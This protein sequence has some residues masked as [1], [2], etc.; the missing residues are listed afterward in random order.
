M[1]EGDVDIRVHTGD[2]GSELSPTDT[3]T[4]R[5]DDHV[6]RLVV[7]LRIENRV[8]MNDAVLRHSSSASDSDRSQLSSPFRH[9]SGTMVVSATSRHAATASRLKQGLPA[10]I[11]DPAIVAKVLR[12]LTPPTPNRA[13]TP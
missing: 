2:A 3:G 12:L 6:H 9:S 7:G 5:G 10:T 13:R 8:R 1:V 11:E 4:G